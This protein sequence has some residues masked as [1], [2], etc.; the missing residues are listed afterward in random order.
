[1]IPVSMRHP[2]ISMKEQKPQRERWGRG[3]GFC[4]TTDALTSC[5]VEAMVE[6][7]TVGLAELVNAR[8][9][10]YRLVLDL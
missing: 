1:M 5:E 7:M 6:L 10:T 9:G 3:R 8:D 4:L 2:I